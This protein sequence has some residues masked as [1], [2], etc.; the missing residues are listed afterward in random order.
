M[1]KEFLKEILYKYVSKNL[2]DRPKQGFGMSVNEWLRGPLRD[3][4]EDLISKSKLPDEDLLNGY[5]VRKTWDEHIL[6]Q[7]TGNINF[8]QF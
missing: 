8:G 5:L 6:A 1:A 4:V 2:V 7:E 3:W